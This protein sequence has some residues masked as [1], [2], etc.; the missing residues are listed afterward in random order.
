M[1]IPAVKSGR[2]AL[3]MVLAVHL[4]LVLA[5]AASAQDADQPPHMIAQRAPDIQPG[6]S[7][8]VC[9]RVVPPGNPF[10][11]AGP[12]NCGSAIRAVK[13]P[14]PG[15][16]VN[17]DQLMAVIGQALGAAK[18]KEVRVRALQAGRDAADPGAN[19]MTVSK[20]A[21]E[22]YNNYLGREESGRLVIF[23]DVEV[24]K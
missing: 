10:K 7:I 9:W 19:L 21:N 12:F 1:M 3:W 5:T 23:L 22:F 17:G 2:P 4:C 13:A 15:G 11:A 14:F 8:A 16:A 20:G 18:I 6:A 24:E